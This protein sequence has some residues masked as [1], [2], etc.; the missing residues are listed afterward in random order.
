MPSP[1]S[2]RAAAT[3]SQV[4]ESP[5]V[6]REPRGARRKRETRMRLMDAALRLMAENGMEGV[7]VNEITE[8][9]DV[10]FGSF[11][12]HFESKE[13]IHAAVADWVFEEFA[14]RLDRLTAELADP[15]EVVAVC[16][17]HTLLRAR[18]EPVWG[19][20]LLREAYS[21]RAMS[22]GLGRRLW[23]DIQRGIKD[24]RFDVSDPFLSFIAVGG[25]ALAAIATDLEFGKVLGDEAARLRNLGFDVRDM[26][27]RTA[28]EALTVLGVD[29]VEAH[30]IAN[31]ALPKGSVTAADGSI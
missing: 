4:A 5:T 1:S 21:A 20:F 26:P 7:A 28:T 15:A 17:R 9:A 2:R 10:G 16:V 25:A 18:A 8:L 31:R 29:R 3:V 24:G 12:N 27:E 22:R 14:D 19:R 23:R 30:E 6:E 13:A 11:Y